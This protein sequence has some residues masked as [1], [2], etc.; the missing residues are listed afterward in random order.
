MR[1]EGRWAGQAPWRSS[2][3]WGSEKST[4]YWTTHRVVVVPPR[5]VVCPFV[6]AVELAY[7]LSASAFCYERGACELS[8]AKRL[9]LCHSHQP[10]VRFF[11]S[12]SSFRFHLS[13]ALSRV[14]AIVA[15]FE[16]IAGTLIANSMAWLLLKSAHR[17]ISGAW[18][19]ESFALKSFEFIVVLYGRGQ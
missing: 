11:S 13:A 19:S 18:N 16:L 1:G 17:T 3:R 8:L 7:R 5:A 2:Q 12:F 14:V 4:I 15:G 9:R 10:N 6:Y